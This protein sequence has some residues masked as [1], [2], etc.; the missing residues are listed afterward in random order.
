M[1]LIILHPDPR[2]TISTLPAPEP[3]PPALRR[4]CHLRSADLQPQGLIKLQFRD[5][6][7][8]RTCGVQPLQHAR[9]CGALHFQHRDT[10][11]PIQAA[12][13][14]GNTLL[15]AIVSAALAKRYAIAIGSRTD[16]G[17]TRIVR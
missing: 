7:C 4:M 15:S 9:G 17:G 14:D 10:R 6:L 12:R 8:I 5:R 11:H 16:V 2:L 1:H 3:H 13:I